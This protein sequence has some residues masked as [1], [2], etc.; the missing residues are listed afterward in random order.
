MGRNMKAKENKQLSE[1]SIK[2]RITYAKRYPYLNEMHPE[3]RADY[4]KGKYSAEDKIRFLCPVCGEYYK[5]TT[6][7]KEKGS[8][9][10]LAQHL[11][12]PEHKERTKLII[13]SVI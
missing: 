5:Q 3:D 6:K 8:Y 10:G 9:T 1:A 11:S 2:R 13:L 7:T 4:L 12:E